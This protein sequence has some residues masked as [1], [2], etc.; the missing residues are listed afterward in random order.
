MVVCTMQSF[1]AEQSLGKPN[2]RCATQTQPRKTT[3]VQ[4]LVIFDKDNGVSVKQD[5]VS[6]C[7]EGEIVDEYE[8]IISSEDEEFKLRARIRQLEDQ[9]GDLENLDVLSANLA[10]QYSYQK[11]QADSKPSAP[12]VLP[13]QRDYQDFQPIPV[14]SD[15][16]SFSEDEHPPP[17]K[18]SKHKIK[19]MESRKQGYYDNNCDYKRN[20]F[21]RRT[22]SQ[23]KKRRHDH[24]HHHH[25]HHSHTCQHFNESIIV[26]PLD[27]GTDDEICEYD[28][29]VD[30]EDDDEDD[31]EDLERLK[32]S[33]AKLR[34]ALAR[35][36][37][38]DIKPKYSLKERLQARIRQTPSPRYRSPQTTTDQVFKTLHEKETQFDGSSP[39]S[40]SINSEN[41]LE[42]SPEVQLR[43]LALKSV[44]LKKHYARKKRD[45]ERAYSPTDMIKRV[46]PTINTDYDID[47]LMDIS[48][49]A[50]PERVTSPVEYHVSNSYENTKAVD[51][52][53]ADTDSDQGPSHYDQWHTDWPQPQ[54]QETLCGPLFSDGNWNY[55]M[56][57]S[58]P[59]VPMTIVIDDDDEE[60]YPPP[61]PSYHIPQVLIDDD[62]ARDAHSLEPT[63]HS[64]HGSINEIQSISMENSRSKSVIKSVAE[65]SDDEAGVLRAMLLS[66]LKTNVPSPALVSV[67][68]SSEIVPILDPPSPETD[69]AEELR[70]QLLS[71]IAAK[72]KTD[73]KVPSPAILKKAVRRFQMQPIKEEASAKSDIATSCSSNL[74]EPKH[75]AE[76]MDEQ[77]PEKLATN[78][79]KP[80]VTVAIEI[81]REPIKSEKTEATSV[82]APSEIVEIT[83]EVAPTPIPNENVPLAAEK[84]I[85]PQPVPSPSAE[86]LENCSAIESS[87]TLT[88]TRNVAP[89]KPASTSKALQPVAPNGRQNLPMPGVIKIVK[90]NKVINKTTT[91]KRK[92]AMLDELS[93]KRPA[94][95]LIKEGGA[96]MH[97]ANKPP[98]T[99]RLITKYD[100]ASIKINRVVV[101]LAESST[102]SDDELMDLP[103]NELMSRFGYTKYSDNASPLSLT[104]GSASNS[105]T[106]SNTPNSEILESSASASN[107]RRVVINEY[108]EKRLDDFLKQARSNCEKSP[109]ELSST[110]QPE[111]ANGIAKKANEEETVK[112]TTP[113]AVEK[114]TD[115]A[116]NAVAPQPK[117]KTQTSPAVKHLPMESQREYVRLIER[118]KVLEKRKKI[119]ALK[120]STNKA[121]ATEK[122][123][124]P[125][126]V[127]RNKVV[128]A[129]AAASSETVA[130]KPPSSNKVA[131]KTTAVATKAAGINVNPV[132]VNP[133]NDSASASAA[134]VVATV[135]DAPAQP[136]QVLT[137]KNI[138]ILKT[139]TDVKLPVVAAGHP[140][141][142]K[143]VTAK[144]AAIPKAQLQQPKESRLKSFESSFLKIGGSMIANL[145]KSLHMVEEAKKSKITRLRC[146]QRLKELYA[147]MQA[148]KQAVK[149]EEAKLARIQ[150]EIQASHEIIISLK[151][152]RSKLYN[153]AMDLGKSIK[154]DDYRLLDEGKSEIKRKSSELTKEIQ[155][156]QDS[157]ATTAATKSL[158]EST[159][160]LPHDEAK[161]ADPTEPSCEPKEI[162]SAS[163]DKPFQS[164][165]FVPSEQT[166]EL[167]TVE[168]LDAAEAIL[169]DCDTIVAAEG[170]AEGEGATTIDAVEK[171]IDDIIANEAATSSTKVQAPHTVS[172][173]KELREEPIKESLLKE[174]HTPMSRNYNSQVDVNGMI[175]PFELMGRCED[176]DC[177]Y[178]HLPVVC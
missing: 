104:M 16:S 60:V 151:Q 1:G 110:E 40:T 33:R 7:E 142:Q 29:N 28:I 157:P 79:V 119:E 152:K 176:T 118:M 154:G 68:V 114:G 89:K 162:P 113:T 69:E 57:S 130:L 14:L 67:P 171:S 103:I 58:L 168:K 127:A 94:T 38:Y 92:T 159:A 25:H 56:P 50:S 59:A 83:K 75:E 153:A 144:A 3:H 175:C 148:V 90:P 17:R 47:D 155:T 136:S 139:V 70:L 32:L 84:V 131:K 160:P 169:E 116:N 137:K 88:I 52:D 51:M 74:N 132:N 129:T 172:F 101:N 128:E 43:L 18:Y 161:I 15:I 6:E 12:S 140:N 166:T 41:P 61:P 105:T 63:E 125:A 55:N 71:S 34:V 120:G 124:V 39:A 87:S 5:G 81:E 164:Q 99:S 2:S 20:P 86:Q 112:S 102:D 123:M 31:D 177:S 174:Y 10:D 100:S 156:N 4:D 45:A 141:A 126:K 98:S 66:K 149:Q 77:K 76:E 165:P 111:D 147:E 173:M 143:T 138:S 36:G 80:E 48:P 62:D 170:S 158:N 46:H 30:E 135:T 115:E 134:Q 26:E 21:S 27:R 97:Y 107:L 65:S 72:R 167:A 106:R 11:P 85:P 53:L 178:M 22:H 42:E 37:D 44:I 108:F 78:E 19:R 96:P 109:E 122:P 121:T 82:P 91:V 163:K 9:N 24:H 146:S 95:L 150:P 54:R 35:N 8:M 145:D 117:T 73:D 49:A 13:Q 64:N 23:R 93:A 133:V